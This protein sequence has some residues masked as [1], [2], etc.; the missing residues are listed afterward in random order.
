MTEQAD[1]TIITPDGTLSLTPNQAEIIFDAYDHMD[2]ADI[3][4][5]VPA[6]ARDTSGNLI[7]RHNLNIKKLVMGELLMLENFPRE[8]AHNKFNFFFTHYPEVQTIVEVMI[9]SFEDWKKA[10]TND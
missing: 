4:S 5:K 8:E 9:T 7:D 2:W 1:M 6:G 3:E 10:Q